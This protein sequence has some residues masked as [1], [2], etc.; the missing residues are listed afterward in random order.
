M[1][2]FRRLLV[3]IAAFALLAAACG[4][5]DSDADSAVP[6]GV[7]GDAVVFAAASLADAFTEIGD[8]FTAANPD[9]KAT[10]SFDASSALVQQITEGAPADVFASADA[11]NMDK[12][13]D[14]GLN[15]GEPVV[16]ATN[17]LAI[18]VAPDNPL[19]ITG[20]ADLASTDIKTVVC[21]EEVPCGRYARQIFDNAG[22]AVTP[23]SFEQNVRAVVTKVT[24][25][26]ADAGIVYVTDITAAGDAAAMVEI[27]ADINVLAEYPIATV[28]DAANAEVGQAFI[29][30]VLGPE[31]QAILSEHGFGAP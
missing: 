11:A 12:L 16:F 26:E 2:T 13:T 20:V 4:S 9:A 22:V 8:A 23:V 3:P 25:G 17:L 6:A 5:D 27:P 30:F 1:K 10:F 31:G 21:A 14:A 29:E 28:E 15:G 18:I 24:A 19:G 7:E